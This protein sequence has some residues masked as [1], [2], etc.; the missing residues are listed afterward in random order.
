MPK[1]VYI[2]KFNLT[3]KVCNCEYSSQRNKSKYCS[4]ICR[5][6]DW[7]KNNKERDYLTKEKWKSNNPERHRQNQY[8]YKRSKLETDF[9]YKLKQR[10]RSRLGRIK[11]NNS[12]RTLEW[13]GCSIS[14]LKSYLEL[15]FQFNMTWT[16]YGLYGWHID[17]IKPLSL[18]NLEN[19]EQL[20]QACHYTNLQ[21]MWAKDNLKKGAKYE[22]MDDQT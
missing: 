13:L 19:S 8:E 6:I 17:H 1:G 18:F 20:K 4:N 12:I 10:I 21:P 5:N 3:C 11:Y 16:N 9:E 7:R 14:E 22:Q 15:R 2:I